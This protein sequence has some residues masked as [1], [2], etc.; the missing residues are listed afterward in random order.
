M[1]NETCKATEHHYFSLGSLDMKTYVIACEKCGD[2]K[3]F[4]LKAESLLAEQSA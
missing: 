1:N 4:Q 3:Q 2:I